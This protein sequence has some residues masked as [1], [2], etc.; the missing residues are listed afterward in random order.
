VAA[1][2]AADIGQGIQVAADAIDS[3]RALKK[4][5]DLIQFTQENG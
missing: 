4:L 3:G 5:N 1:D 2:A